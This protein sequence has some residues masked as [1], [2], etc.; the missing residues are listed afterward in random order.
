ML[1][2]KR[3]IAIIDGEKKE[4]E[5]EKEKEANMSWKYRLDNTSYLFSFFKIEMMKGTNP[6][7]Q[8]NLL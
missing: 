2:Q 5:K 6:L 4:K 1:I 8:P 3:K 7:S